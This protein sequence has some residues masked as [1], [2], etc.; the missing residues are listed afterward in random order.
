[1]LSRSTGHRRSRATAA[2]CGICALFVAPA[3]ASSSASGMAIATPGAPVLVGPPIS[4]LP[5]PI[6]L[7]TFL[8][9]ITPQ[10]TGTT[11]AFIFTNTG[12][13]AA[14]AVV[15]LYAADSGAQLATYTTA[16]VPALGT[17]RVAVADVIAGATPKLT[18]T[19]AA[20]VLNAAVAGAFRGDVQLVN[21]SA[22]AVTNLSSC[23]QLAPARV[24]G[25]VAGPGNMAFTDA[26]RIANAGTVAR[27]VTLII[28]DAADGSSLGTWTSADVP[29]HASLT[30]S[31]TA[32]AAAANPPVAATKANLVVIPGIMSFGLS[33]RHL[34][35]VKG[36]TAVE[37][38]T[39]VCAVYGMPTPMLLGPKTG[40]AADDGN[41]GDDGGASN[42]APGTDAGDDNDHGADAA[43][44]PTP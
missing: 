29:A 31:A 13:K 27:K 21:A 9:A 19:Q 42:D 2:V 34:S 24:L 30:I 5:M 12:T 43:T 38:L 17:L 11:S 20:A 25:N 28:R 6:I 32:L 39:A 18:A 10:A 14:T 35:Q 44:P 3:F 36:A 4:I 33:L 22:N 37:D 8:P 40:A 23:S 26:V 7:G 16:S 41:A 15:T 1:M